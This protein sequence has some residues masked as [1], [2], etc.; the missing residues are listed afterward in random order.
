MILICDDDLCVVDVRGP[1]VKW[2]SYVCMLIGRT[3]CEWQGLHEDGPRVEWEDWIPFCRNTRARYEVAWANITVLDPNR[4]D[5]TDEPTAPKGVIA[6]SH[7]AWM[8]K[9][10][11]LDRKFK[12]KGQSSSGQETGWAQVKLTGA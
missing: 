5:V 9:A 10:R 4:A 8:G 11:V 6:E 1:V 2:T 7:R 3:R 12:K